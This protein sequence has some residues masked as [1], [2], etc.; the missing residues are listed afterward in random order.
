P[1]CGSNI[2][3]IGDVAQT[4]QPVPDT[5]LKRKLAQA[6]REGL[7]MKWY[8]FIIYVQCFLGGLIGLVNFVG[9]SSGNQYGDSASLVYEAYPALKTVDV[10]YGISN[11]ALAVLLVY[12]CFGLRKFKASSLRLYLYYPLV[13]PIATIL[14]L[15]AMQ[16]VLNTTLPFQDVVTQFVSNIVLFI[17]N[18]RYFGRRKHLFNE[19]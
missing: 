4:P 3:V 9:F 12:V 5:L 14:Y 2:G 7:G 15:L 1:K 17:A 8:K 16:T 6:E 13:Y 19:A 18:F 10:V 11:L